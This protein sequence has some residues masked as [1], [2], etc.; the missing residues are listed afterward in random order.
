MNRYTFDGKTHLHNETR[1]LV[2]AYAGE[3]IIIRPTAKLVG[4]EKM[5]IGD[6]AKIDDFTLIAAGDDLRIGSFCH[7]GAYTSILG[8]GDFRM[9]DF[10]SLSAGV[11]LWTGSDDFKGE[12]MGNSAIPRKYRKVNMDGVVMGEH[13]LVGSGA[14]VLPGVNIGVGAAV[15][16]G[17][18]VTG[19][20]APWT[21]YA[22]SPAR[23]IGTRRSDIIHEMEREL[24]REFYGDGKYIPETR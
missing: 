7:V 18:L 20:L 17:A 10:S 24:M 11:R 1:H 5:T 4:A 6:H 23:K 14:I 13:S 9:G 15:G 3:D 19:D 8:G 21:I 16:A 2:F 22:G 12:A